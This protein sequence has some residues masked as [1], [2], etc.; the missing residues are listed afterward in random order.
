MTTDT[1]AEQAKTLVELAVECGIEKDR[2]LFLFIFGRLYPAP[3]PV[4]DLSGMLDGI[5]KL[6]PELAKMAEEKETPSACTEECKI[7]E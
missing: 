3:E 7:T 1:C 5:K 4:H 6:I 2:D